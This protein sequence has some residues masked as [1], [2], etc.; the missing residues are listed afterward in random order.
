[1]VLCTLPCNSPSPCDPFAAQLQPRQRGRLLQVLLWEHTKEM[2]VFVALG[3]GQL[4]TGQQ[5]AS[6]SVA[7]MGR[8]GPSR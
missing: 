6:K 1:M 3:L 8:G 7:V 4:S 5:R 2:F